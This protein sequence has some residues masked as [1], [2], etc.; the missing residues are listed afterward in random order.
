MS[1]DYTFVV[2]LPS[3]ADDPYADFVDLTKI[4]PTKPVSSILPGTAEK[5]EIFRKRA[6]LG[7]PLWMEGDG[8]L[9]AD[10]QTPHDD[11]P[12]EEDLL[13]DELKE[14]VDEDQDVSHDAKDSSLAEAVEVQQSEGT[15]LLLDREI[16]RKEAELRARGVML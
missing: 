16:L 10:F 15:L 12:S 13:H 5:L 11:G 6:E 7:L 1:D 4:D 2:E 3:Q 14:S 8:V 9:R